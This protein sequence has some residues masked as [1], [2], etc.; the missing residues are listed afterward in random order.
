MHRLK[1]G[2]EIIFKIHHSLYYVTCS[3]VMK[4]KPFCIGEACIATNNG[5]ATLASTES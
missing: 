4:A 2:L 1:K 5:T 3:C